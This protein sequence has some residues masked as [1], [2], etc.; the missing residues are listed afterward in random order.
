MTTTPP[1]QKVTVFGGGSFGTALAE[2]CAQRGQSV[3]LWMRD[4]VQARA[5]NETHHNPRYLSDHELHS[6]ISATSDLGVALSEPDWIIIA[7]PSQAVRALLEQCRDD[8]PEVPL[9]LAAKGIENGT[10]KTMDEVVADV[11]GESWSHRTMAM[12]GPSFAKEIVQGLPT[13]VVVAC[14]DEA[15]SASICDT[16]FSDVFRAYSS[17]DIVGVEIGGALKNVMAIAAGG[18]I[19]MGLGM[20]VR[21]ALVTRGLSEMTKIALAKGANPLTL[22]GLAGVGDLLLTC[23]GGLSR[24][25]AV[26]QAL[27]EGKSLQ[28]AQEAI[29]QVAEGVRTAKSAYELVKSLEVDCPII[30]TVYRVIYEDEPVME[31]F[32]ALVRRHPG[33]EMNYSTQD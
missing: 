5:I 31:A 30:E 2:L 10:L 18:V 11:L 26:G 27:G 3:C 23:T 8:F 22:S 4:E 33:Q 14:R 6:G 28:E 17:S 7:I 16:L 9:V 1:Y 24:N 13:S 19:G 32:R 15:L 21:A 12:S 20:N 29:G 25:R